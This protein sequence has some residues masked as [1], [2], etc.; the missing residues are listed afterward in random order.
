MKKAV[1]L[2]MLMYSGFLNASIVTPEIASLVAKNFY[3]ERAFLTDP[4]SYR[5]LQ[6][7]LDETVKGEDLVPLYY[8]FTINR[9]GFV[10]VSA[11]EKCLPVLGF[12]FVGLLGRKVD[13]C[14]QK[15]KGGED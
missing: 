2:L 8:I 12:A 1:L 15:E 14:Q 10:L 4:L 9:G 11:S 7:N 6:A 13:C 3:A 5:E